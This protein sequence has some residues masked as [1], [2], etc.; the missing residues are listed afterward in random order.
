MHPGFGV[1]IHRVDEGEGDVTK[2]GRDVDDDG[3]GMGLEVQAASNVGI[4]ILVGLSRAKSWMSRGR[5]RPTLLSRQSVLRWST[6]NLW[7]DGGNGADVACIEVIEGAIVEV[8]GGGLQVGLDTLN[9]DDF[10]ND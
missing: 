8:F 5:W 4:D 9:N 3:V 6:A 10:P 2:H 1:V 7:K